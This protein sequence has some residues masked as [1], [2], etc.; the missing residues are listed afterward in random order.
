MQI[1]TSQWKSRSDD[2]VHLLPFLD[3]P[4]FVSPQPSHS[5]HVPRA[6]TCGRSSGQQP[7]GTSDHWTGLAYCCASS[8]PIGAAKS[9][10]NSELKLRLFCNQEKVK[11]NSWFEVFGEC[12]S[13]LFRYLLSSQSL[14][15]F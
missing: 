12:L 14:R 13:F 4:I 8:F 10:P 2:T 5:K 1:F 9:S 15:N 7:K 3:T 6:E 11:S